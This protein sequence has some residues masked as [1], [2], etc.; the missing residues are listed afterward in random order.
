MV[1]GDQNDVD[2]FE[3]SV[4][5]INKVVEKVRAVIALTVPLKYDTQR[6]N[7]QESPSPLDNAE[8]TVRPT[9]MSVN[10]PGL[11]RSTGSLEKPFAH[12]A[13]LSFHDPPRQYVLAQKMHTKSDSG[14]VFVLRS[15]QIIEE[16]D[17]SDEESDPEDRDDDDKTT[18]SFPC[19]D[20]KI[21]ELVSRM[22]SLS[23]GS[24]S[25]VSRP[26]ITPT[27]VRTRVFPFVP[28][29]S[30]VSSPV[31]AF[32][33]L[34]AHPSTVQCATPMEI[35]G[36]VLGRKVANKGATCPQGVSE[37]VP[38]D[39]VVFHPEVKDVEMTDAFATDC[40]LPR[41]TLIYGSL[42]IP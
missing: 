31:A 23:L 8:G 41:A 4:G 24:T 9:Q 20:S 14:A 34:V 17:S 19:E 6:V 18:Y 12:G 37:A 13:R 35:D 2:P 28:A 16:E 36:D 7:L 38:M 1:E 39:G 11:G 29:R 21:N 10:V 25:T 3:I 42:L 33:P 26:T 32:H 27:R 22:V 40:K 5:V 15:S 30:P